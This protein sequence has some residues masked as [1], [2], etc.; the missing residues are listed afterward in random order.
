VEERDFHS[1]AAAGS[2]NVRMW[3]SQQG[4]LHCQGWILPHPSL[5]LS[6]SDIV[7]MSKN[8]VLTN[9]F[10]LVVVNR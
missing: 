2:C 9:I 5:C 10:H 4:G 7:Q 3:D 8:E 1:Y 6:S